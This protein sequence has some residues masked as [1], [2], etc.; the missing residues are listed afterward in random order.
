[1]RN[2]TLDTNNR[3]SVTF[4]RTMEYK[5]ISTYWLRQVLL[6]QKPLKSYN[7]YHE[8]YEIIQMLVIFYRQ[9]I[10]RVWLISA[11]TDDW[12]SNG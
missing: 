8:H 5:G 10:C 7:N 11:S 6:C 2:S 4:H 1:M 9:H 3:F 12:Y